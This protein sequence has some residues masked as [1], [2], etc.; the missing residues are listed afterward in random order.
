MSPRKWSW[1]A[2]ASL[3][4]ALAAC[5]GSGS[6]GLDNENS[7]V[8][9]VAGDAV[10]RDYLGMMVCAADAPPSSPGM[11]QVLTTLGNAAPVVCTTPA[12]EACSFDFSFAPR[13]FA[14]GTPFRVAVRLHD[15]ESQWVLGPEP[16]AGGV[17]AAPSFAA[18]LTAPAAAGGSS[19]GSE[20][21]DVAVVAFA[22]P[23][24]KLPAQVIELVELGGTAAFVS[25]DH[26]VQR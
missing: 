12:S 24:A 9:A 18:E 3:S 4:I 17:L 5:G 25:V 14:A 16:S 11:M 13:G 6:S 20:A 26:P 19:S 21:V 2:L 8:R 22:S 15:P 7:V 23:P 10:C 1:L